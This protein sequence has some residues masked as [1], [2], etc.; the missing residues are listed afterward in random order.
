MTERDTA[1]HRALA[2]YMGELRAARAELAALREENAA[3][4]AGQA[5]LAANEA[6]LRLAL[7]AARMAY[8]DWDAEGDRTSGSVGREALYGRP[9]GSLATTQAVLDAVH[10]ADRDRC[11]ATIR[12]AQQRPPGEQHFDQ[13]EFRVIDPDGT[14]RWLCSQGRV[15]VHDPRTGQALRAAGVT[16]DITQR[17]EAETRSR[18]LFDGA[19]FAIIVMEQGTHRI[20]D[21]NARACADYGYSPAEFRRLTI[22]DIDTLGNRAAISKHVQ[23]H[24]VA[25]GTYEFEAEHRTRDGQLR[26]VLVRVQTIDLGQGRVTYSAHV[27]ITAR[28]AAEAALRRSEERLRVAMAAG[29]L[30]AWEVDTAAGWASWDARMATMLGDAAAP[31]GSGL[32][33]FTT[34][35]HPEDQARVEAAFHAAAAGEQDYA[36]EFRI[37]RP[38]GEERWLRSWGRL[39]PPNRPEAG[40]GARPGADAPTRMA[41]VI[42]DITERRRAEEHQTL[43]S[44]EIDHRAKNVLA[45][46]QA[47]LRLTPRHDPEA[48]AQMVEGRI[49]ALA[50]AHSLLAA[51][52]WVG[53]DLAALLQAELQAFLSPAPADDLAGTG[54]RRIAMTGPA[55]LITPSQAQAIGM[56]MHELATNAVKY[57]ALSRSGGQV[58]L[59]WRRDEAKGLLLLSWEETGGPPVAECPPASGFGTRMVN[60]MLERQLGGRVRRAWRREG[61]LLE[62]E[63]PLSTSYAG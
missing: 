6:R 12:N 23:A 1:A 33:E 45:V 22:S 32:T 11:A 38:N 52:R 40:P 61:L 35:L 62:A 13:V 2:A 21:V 43:L 42:A 39:L 5:A 44:R 10:P 31:G 4:R 37:R 18:A 54:A 36:A 17:R 7:D 20:L 46:V 26:D 55:L 51:N 63:L 8:W 29:D 50:R 19:P 41:G 59:G 49:A 53:V 27:D 3:L 58:R 60:A 16:Y 47:A 9:E 56:T 14:V 24:K 25:D 48:Y 30:G 28:K 34:R 57:G 15:T